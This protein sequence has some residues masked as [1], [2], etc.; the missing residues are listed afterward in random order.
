MS[1]LTLTANFLVQ[2]GEEKRFLEAARK[3]LEPTRAES[4][5]IDYRL[6][7]SQDTP[8]AFVFYENWESRADL[9]RHLETPHIKG[10]V[11]EIE[12]ILVAPIE[13]SSWDEIA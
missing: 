4:G 13:L 6:H 12:P 10:F 11:A 1:K 7:R 9:D 3:V 2:P 8:G 5:C